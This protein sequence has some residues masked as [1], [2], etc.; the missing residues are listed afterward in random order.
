M[1]QVT[2]QCKGS[3]QNAGAS[4]NAKKA[5]CKFCQKSVPLAS[6]GKLRKHMRFTTKAK[7]RQGR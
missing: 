6:T 2:V 4:H 1:T 7:L 5:Q 3:G